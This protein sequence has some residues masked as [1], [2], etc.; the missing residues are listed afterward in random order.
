MSLLVARRSVLLGL[1]TGFFLPAIAFAKS[2]AEEKS[3]YVGTRVGR[4]MDGKDVMVTRQVGAIGGYDDRL[5]AIAVA[6][7]AGI[8]PAVVVNGYKKKWHALEVSANFFRGGESADNMWVSKI[9]GL[10][11]NSAIAERRKILAGIDLSKSAERLREKK[12]IAS[13]VLGVEESEIEIIAYS[14]ARVAGKINL[15]ANLGS[16]VAGQHGPEK[17]DSDGFKKG[18][19][20]AIEIKHSELDSVSDAAAVLFHET[21]HRLDYDFT[22][23]WAGKYETDTRRTFSSALFTAW[24]FKRDTSELSRADAEIA[25][26]V[27]A[28]AHGSTEARAYARTFMAALEAGAF[29]TAQKQLEA[30]ASGLTSKPQR[31]NPP[32]ARYVQDALGV[33][34][35]TVYRRSTTDEKKKFDAAF[36]SIKKSYASAWISSFDHAKAMP[37]K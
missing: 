4:N 37:K 14:S 16:G 11:S 18:A 7:M 5:Q 10:P 27:A 29:D 6:R 15:T 26:D 12:F 35:E 13:L 2:A 30:Y 3:V 20:T 32:T 8:N 31:V 21:S 33:E 34:L 23:V 19:K 25:S 24:L 22:Q 9:F 36:A 28:S 17:N 1:A